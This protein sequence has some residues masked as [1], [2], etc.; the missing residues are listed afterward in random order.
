MVI[1]RDTD[2]Y[3]VAIL[4]PMSS[5]YLALLRGINVGGRNRILM[6]DL[7]ACLEAAGYEDVRT[8]IQSGNVVF[9]S[10]L[11]DRAEL[12]SDLERI[13][14]GSFDYRATIE[15]RDVAQMRAVVE[16]APAGFGGQPDDYRYDV[17]FLLAPL[18]PD[19][20][21]E[22][23]TLKEGIDAA[24]PG[25]GVVY[26]SR[27]IERATQSGLSKIASHRAYQ[28]MTIRNWRTT[29]KLLAIMAER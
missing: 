22:A 7:R 9:R 19:A 16:Q 17:M 27:L 20:A 6:A 1:A 11:G 10:D 12:T 25:P 24:W 23:L 18:A 3:T 29:T 8:Y 14:T 15:L 26:T 2:G 21:L 28:R 5:T 13:L 4:R